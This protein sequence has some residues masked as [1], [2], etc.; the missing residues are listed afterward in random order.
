[1]SYAY[2]KE[3]MIITKILLYQKKLPYK[4][5]VNYFNYLPLFGGFSIFSV[6]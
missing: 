6:L 3:F 5:W 1:M 2:D 4:I